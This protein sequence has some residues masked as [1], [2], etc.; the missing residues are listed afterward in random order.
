VFPRERDPV[1][2]GRKLEHLVFEVVS[3]ESL[4]HAANKAAKLIAR[5]VRR[6]FAIDV[7]R[8]RALEWSAALESWSILDTGA[9]IEDVALAAPLP[10]DAL[11]RSAKAD[12]A[13]ARALVIKRNPVIEAVGAQREALGKAESLVIVL[14]T[15][16][17]AP[18]I[19]E[20]ARILAERDLERLDRWFA[21][22]LHCSSVAELLALS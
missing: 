19:A 1:T 6:A 21:A 18:S 17:L 9:Y 4:S 20:R 8:E 14:E 22:V 15:R 3:T 7:E 2:G 11:I 10:I 16:G 12:D 13:M 5:G